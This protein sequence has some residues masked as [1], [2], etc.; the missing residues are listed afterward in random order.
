[1]QSF[2][3]QVGVP[4]WLVVLLG[5]VSI[6]GAY[7]IGR[8][9]QRAAAAA[10]AAAERIER[11]SARNADDD[12][13]HERERALQQMVDALREIATAPPTVPNVLAN[14]VLAACDLTGGSGAMV[15]VREGDDVVCL[16]SIGSVAPPEGRR[17]PAGRAATAS[18]IDRDD[19]IR[20]GDTLA[21]EL[22]DL[23]SEI[24]AR[25]M[26]AVPLR[27]RERTVGALTV[28]SDRIDAFDERSTMLIQLVAAIGGSALARA[29]ELERRRMLEERYRVLSERSDEF[30][31]IIGLDGAIRYASASLERVLGYPGNEIM[32]LDP[33]D[34]VHPGDRVRAAA[35]LQEI[36]AEPGHT[37]VVTLRLR[38]AD[39][40]YR[41]IEMFSRNLS[42]MPAVGG[43]VTNGRDITD[44]ERSAEVSH[45]QGHLLDA[46]QQA[47]IATDR[48]GNVTFWSRSAEL[49]YGWPANEVMGM[50]LY[51]L[52]APLG[53]EERM[54]QSFV[55][56]DR[57]VAENGA[58]VAERSLRRRDGRPVLV[59]VTLSSVTGPS[60]EMVGLV[61]VSED[62]AERRKLEEQLR[63]SQKME[64]VGRLAGGIAH[65]FNNLLTVIRANTDF[66]LEELVDLPSQH[67]EVAEI[68]SAATRA[69]TL[70]RQLLA[71]SRQ[72]VL[73]PREL[74]ISDLVRG[75]Q[76]L[77]NRVIGDD[78]RVTSHLSDTRNCVLADAG[79]IE[80][81]LMNL[82]VNSRDAM[83]RG[84]TVTIE[85][86]HA[87]IGDLVADQHSARA[88]EYVTLSVSDTGD[89]MDAETVERIFEPFFTTKDPGKGTG[90]GLSMVHGIVKQSG[91]F[92]RV[93]STLGIGTRF[94]I[95][96]PL[97]SSAG[98]T[99]TPARRSTPHP[100]PHSRDARNAIGRVA[101]LNGPAD[102]AAIRGTILV[103]EDEDLVRL[104]ACRVLTR[105]G[106]HVVEAKDGIE[107]L[108]AVTLTPG[109]FDLVLTDAMMPR[110]GGVDLAKTLVETRPN[111]Q[112]L[113]MSGFTDVEHLRESGLEGKVGFLAK[114]FTP[115]DLTRAVEEQ[116]E[117]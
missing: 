36:G 16:A 41:T 19:I 35:L 17:V 56:A 23:L 37:A 3:S 64:A 90:L 95:H 58:R 55:T 72:T 48:E 101:T 14:V 69:A 53:E 109:R 11:V 54:R 44:R 59:R 93:D 27:D 83:P 25:S 77:L 68:Q 107:A 34:L 10:V 50:P 79:Q 86:S 74:D 12:A 102:A 22:G 96:L 80:Q 6:A 67:A 105:R 32:T 1:M 112:I 26:L 47:V 18:V 75:V 61:G 84:G 104:L 62:V 8:W 20:V 117:G 31:V 60:G 15:T 91:G 49:L 42:D 89:G 30:V 116:L 81:V 87:M 82:V 70:T 39:G 33:I 114:P 73:Q 71:F 115:D 45:F 28:L 88:G 106:F 78:V 65:D 43:I 110:M 76:A 5:T 97:V 2:S 63:Q 113:L 9:R 111:L 40:R 51:T 57:F 7:L 66:L 52:I 4:G 21:H 85:T 100:A 24:G 94:V 46:V 99:G 98:E 29:T 108:E 103:V 38:H 92:I 13:S